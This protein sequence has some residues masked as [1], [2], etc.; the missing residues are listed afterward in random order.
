MIIDKSFDCL[1]T[2]EKE[3]AAKLAQEIFQDYQV[4]FRKTTATA[5]SLPFYMINLLATLTEQQNDPDGDAPYSPGMRASQRYTFLYHLAAD[6]RYPKAYV[7]AESYLK[8]AKA[9]CAALTHEDLKIYCAFWGILSMGKGRPFTPAIPN[10][11]TIT[12]F[13]INATQTSMKAYDD[14]GG[15]IEAAVNFYRNEFN[16]KA[17]ALL[18]PYANHTPA[19]NILV[20]T[21]LFSK[22][23]FYGQERYLTSNKIDM[24]ETFQ[25]INGIK[26][27]SFL[28]FFD[29]AI[30]QIVESEINHGNLIL[31]SSIIYHYFQPNA[32]AVPADMEE[33]I[34]QSLLKM[35]TT[36]GRVGKRNPDNP[37]NYDIA[38]EEQLLVFAI[39]YRRIHGGHVV[40]SYVFDGM[41]R[42]YRH[43]FEEEQ[44]RPMLQSLKI[45][46][47]R[48]YGRVTRQRIAL[49]GLMMQRL[50]DIASSSGRMQNTMLYDKNGKGI[51]YDLLP[52][53]AD[54]KAR[55]ALHSDII[56]VL[57]GW[58][59]SGLLKELDKKAD[60]T[61]IYYKE[62][63]G[64]HGR[65]ESVTLT[66]AVGKTS[67]KGKKSLPPAAESDKI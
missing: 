11:G 26:V 63:R 24:V 48:I 54:N 34:E 32:K 18:P 30:F 13:M 35:L 20:S 27:P 66:P 59:A 31:T 51:F 14:N 28:S 47:L 16:D 2:A 57:D 39:E 23:P 4:Y 56:S 21:D 67:K 46:A 7:S 50:C 15:N 44:R 12:N 25:Y 62:K 38:W 29:Y 45:D 41:S 53:D 49:Q 10:E 52:E 5:E 3:E 37:K 42:W 22:A 65:Y 60:G 58:A 61:P 19:D 64:Q 36:F 43:A 17:A 1:T 8:D 55:S 6:V 9:I 40:K 33:A